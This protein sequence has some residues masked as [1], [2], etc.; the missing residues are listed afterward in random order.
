[1]MQTGEVRK[2]IERLYGAH[3]NIQVERDSLERNVVDYDSSG[4]ETERQLARELTDVIIKLEL[5]LQAY[6]TAKSI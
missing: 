4:G 1:M 3:Y 6:G 2:L 5:A